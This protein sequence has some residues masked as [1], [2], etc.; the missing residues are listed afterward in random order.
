MSRILVFFP[1]VIQEN[2]AAMIFFAVGKSRGNP[3]FPGVFIVLSL[4][5]LSGI[6]L[7]SWS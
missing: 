7:Y 3:E 2:V 5:G 1:Y 6:G 4:R